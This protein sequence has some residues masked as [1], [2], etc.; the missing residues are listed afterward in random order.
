MLYYIAYM[1]G[2]EVILDIIPSVIYYSIIGTIKGMQYI[3]PS[4]KNE[5][6]KIIF[7]PTNEK[8]NLKNETDYEVVITEETAIYDISRILEKK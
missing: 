5:P 8:C 4:K 1:F 3:I 7:C 2:R 6:M